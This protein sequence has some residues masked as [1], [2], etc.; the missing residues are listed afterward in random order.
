VA[1]MMTLISQR[2]RGQ[3]A[4]ADAYAA[5]HAFVQ[6]AY[7][8][9]SRRHLVF[10][11]NGGGWLPFDSIPA[12]LMHLVVL[13]GVLQNAVD[14]HGIPHPILA[15]HADFDRQARIV[16]FSAGESEF[17]NFDRQRQIESKI[18]GAAP[19]LSDEARDALLREAGLTFGPA[20]EKEITKVA[21]A[22]L[23]QLEPFVGK[24]TIVRL[25]FSPMYMVAW[26]VVVRTRAG[27][28]SFDYTLSFEPFEGKLIGLA[29][30]RQ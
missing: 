8:S 23:E 22:Q 11:I 29:R 4:N 9:L 14:S 21:R 26:N 24:A 10:T 6:A 20:A 13:V 3:T 30:H 7:P 5:V 27:T 16:Q 12:P 15:A 25:D 2:S 19:A 1:A 18:Q 17:V 28:Q